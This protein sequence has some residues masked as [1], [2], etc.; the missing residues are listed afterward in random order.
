MVTEKVE[1]PGSEGHMLSARIERPARGAVRGWALFAHCFTC[2]K[3]FVAARRLSQALADDGLAVLRFDFT[4]LG[5]SEGEFADTTFS[6]NVAD[7][8]AGAD[9]LR[10][11]HGA[12]RV[13][14]GHSLGGAAVLA[15]AGEIPEVAAVATIAAPSDPAHVR[16]HFDEA[17]D[18]IRSE[19]RASVT[20]GGRDLTIG[21]YFLDDIERWDLLAR[22]RRLRA[23]LLVFHGPLDAVVSIEHARRLFE[24][25]RHPKS[26]VSLDGADHLLTRDEDS[27]YVGTVLSAWVSRYLPDTAAAADEQPLPQPH[28]VVVVR[29]N[30]LGP[31]SNDVRA[32]RHL[33][34]ADEPE[35]VGGDDSGP[36]PYEYLLA[37]LGACTSMTLR[38]YARHKQ[39]PL[40]QVTVTLSH[41]GVHA[42]DC[43]ECLHAEGR[44]D[45]LERRIAIKGD[46][47]EA[48]RA[49]MLEIADRC[50]VHRTLTGQLEIHTRAEE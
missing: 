27:R 36:T 47:T 31:L 16:R 20:L 29:E 26:F 25:A 48:Q 15:A 12:P 6:S 10:E 7:L 5:A 39:L 3:D 1:F 2:G 13:L 32:G 21:R 40:E 19:G 24:A 4:G 33:L 23:A 41:K 11:N 18:E 28:G 8:V 38:L 42:D 14:V 43:A 49:R 45:V 46:L 37:S 9:W 35:S 22:V 34:P 30:G 50:P 44:I 17:A